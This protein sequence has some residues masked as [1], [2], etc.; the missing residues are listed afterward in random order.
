MA[1]K[2]GVEDPGK[3]EP[4]RHRGDWQE[5]IFQNDTDRE[6]FLSTPDEACAK[7]FWQVQ[8]FAFVSSPTTFISWSRHRC[9]RSWINFP[10]RGIVRSKAAVQIKMPPRSIPRSR[11]LFP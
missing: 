2:L 1:G 5:P 7:T 3:I 6:R 8:A 4:V 11:R 10:R 9:G